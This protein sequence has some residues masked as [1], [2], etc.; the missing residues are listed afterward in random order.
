MRLAKEFVTVAGIV[1]GNEP[2]KVPDERRG[3]NLIS[4]EKVFCH[5]E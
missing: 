4:G 2:E 1:T 5:G 3:T